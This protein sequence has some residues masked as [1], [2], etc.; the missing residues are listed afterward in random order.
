MSTQK[1]VVLGTGGTIAGKAA[2]AEDNVGYKAAEVGVA[3]LLQGV[4]GLGKALQGH[5][6]ESEQIAQIDSKDMGWDVWRTLAMRCQQL[7]SDP[8]VTGVV[9]THGTD[10][11]EET[12]WFLS[13]VLDA[14]KPVVLVSAMRP[15]SS[16]T[17]DGPQ[18]L[19]D[20]IAVATH[21]RVGGVLAVAAGVVHAAEHVHK[22]FPYRVDAFTSGEAGPCGWVE[23]GQVRWAREPGAGCRGAHAV[24]LHRM[25]PA[26]DWPWV[27]VV[28]S[29]AGAS[30]RAVDALVNARVQGLVVAATGNGSIH[31]ALKEALLRAQQQ[32]VCVVTATRC[33]Q[34]HTLVGPTGDFAGAAG[35]SPIKARIQLVL[36]LMSRNGA[37]AV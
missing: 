6:L 22:A 21:P 35:L 17:P 19:L 31:H 33:G 20:A 15:A 4:P 1:I 7:L 12:A 37:Q 13:A 10:T 5:V 30:G 26:A 25:P 11:L 23:E 34:G 24:L 14:S 18:N 29:G 32:G 27:E 9:I 28:C 36:D 8:D 2:S 16:L 3:D